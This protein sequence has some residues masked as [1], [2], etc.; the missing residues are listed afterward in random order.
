MAG[1]DDEKEGGS[2]QQKIQDVEA[3]VAEI[4][5]EKEGGE[6]SRGRD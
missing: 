3:A 5:D 1:I 4:D 6:Q 2:P